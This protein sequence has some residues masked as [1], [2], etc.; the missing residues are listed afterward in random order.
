VLL[1]YL[2]PAP[3]LPLS[4][5]LGISEPVEGPAGALLCLISGLNASPRSSGIV[6]IG[7]YL[8]TPFLYIF[9]M[10]SF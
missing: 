6:Y 10:L 3:V 8:S 5:M 7:S 9:F 2:S 1:D 4:P